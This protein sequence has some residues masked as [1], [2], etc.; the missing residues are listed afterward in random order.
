MDV[1]FSH[2]LTGFFFL[3]YLIFYNVVIDSSWLSSLLVS[4]MTANQYNIFINLSFAY[5]FI[6]KGNGT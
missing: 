5:N 1:Y 4:P 3:H 6:L 2:I